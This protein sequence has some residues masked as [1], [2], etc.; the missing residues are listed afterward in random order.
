MRRTFLLVL[1]VLAG[2]WWPADE[3]SP[4]ADIGTSSSDANTDASNHDA[5]PDASCADT[6]ERGVW[7]YRHP[8]NILGTDHIVGDATEE[9]TA[10]TNLQADQI[11]R[12]YGNYGDRPVNDT[13]SVASWNAQLES[14]GIDSQL[15]I[16]D[17]DDIFPGCRQEMI[18]RVQARLID[19]NA[20]VAAAEQFVALHLD[21]EP[22]QYKQGNAWSTTTTCGQEIQPW[23]FWDD[24]SSTGRAERYDMLRETIIDVRAHLDANGHTATPLYVDLAPWIDSSANFDWST[25]SA[26]TDG[27]DWLTQV[28]TQV[29]GMTFMTYERDS[30]TSIDSAVA[31]ESSLNTQL[32]VSVNARERAPLSSTTTWTDLNAMW[33]V[34]GDLEATHCGARPVDLFNYRY[35]HE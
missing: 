10:R 26:V 28:A 23:A 3:P 13:A 20:S 25:T 5:G 6:A 16:G 15:L 18:Q 2:C 21:I 4:I 27:T 17:G 8:G 14:D 24:L 12:V 7:M 9:M 1:F 31:G 19:F 33:T 29:D 11:T 35:L 30:A 22:Q 34:V 32:R